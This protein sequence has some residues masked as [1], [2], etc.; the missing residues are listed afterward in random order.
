MEETGI[1][2]ELVQKMKSGE[3]I[4][5][6]KVKAQLL[7]FSKKIGLQNDAGELQPDVIK[8]KLM[9]VTQD[10]AKAQEVMDKC[11]VTKDTP[12]DSVFETVKCL[13]QYVPKGEFD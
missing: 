8:A 5:D 9:S 7:C 12:E 11:L 6:P 4:D 13:N 2:M 3:L 1:S 10:E